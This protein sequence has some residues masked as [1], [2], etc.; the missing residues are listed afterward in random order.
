[1]DLH[2]KYW[3]LQFTTD[4]I[5][6][7]LINFGIIVVDQKNEVHVNIIEDWNRINGFAKNTFLIDDILKPWIRDCLMNIKTETELFKI[8][9][10]CDSVYSLIYFTEPRFSISKDGPLKLLDILSKVFL[11]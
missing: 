8:K 5:A 4:Q 1:M 3:V 7:E 6:G 11:K 2:M 10:E 9:E